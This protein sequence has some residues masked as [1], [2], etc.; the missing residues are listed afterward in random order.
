MKYV[1]TF[2]CLFLS[3]LLLTVRPAPGGLSAAETQ[4][5]PTPSPTPSPTPIRADRNS[6]GDPSVFDR[7]WTDPRWSAPVAAAFIKSRLDG[8]YPSVFSGL[9]FDCLTPWIDFVRY[10]ESFEGKLCLWHD[11]P[12]EK[13]LSVGSDRY[14][15]HTVTREWT[16][17]EKTDIEDP[18]L[19]LAEKGIPCAV[20]YT[21][22]IIGALRPLYPR[23]TASP[24]P[25]PTPTPTPTLTP[26]PT[27]VPGSASDGPSS[28]GA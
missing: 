28:S 5:T 22:E 12:E 26:T 2:L 19:L 17:P 3:I 23:P 25:T 13:V 21:K 10:M 24:G 8:L 27:P 18:E 4:T 1:R 9:M 6:F 20:V 7:D 16:G 15:Y 14:T 11:G